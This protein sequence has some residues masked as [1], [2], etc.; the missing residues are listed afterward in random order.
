[1]YTY[2]KAS[3]CASSVD[4]IFACQLYLSKA[5]GKKSLFLTFQQVEAG[6]LQ[7][8]PFLPGLAI[9]RT[10]GVPVRTTDK[11]PDDHS[12]TAS[13]VFYKSLTVLSRPFERPDSV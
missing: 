1:M 9:V 3:H 10:V 6:A 2:I 4:T 11:T 12:S 7:L 13:S 5:G 8:R